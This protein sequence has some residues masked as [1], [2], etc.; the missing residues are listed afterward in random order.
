[1]TELDDVQDDAGRV[2]AEEDEN[3]AKE[4]ETQVDLFALATGGAETFDWNI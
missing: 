2:A 3:D 1:M 4:N